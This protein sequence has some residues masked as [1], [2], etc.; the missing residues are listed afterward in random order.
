MAYIVVGF[1]CFCF[2][3]FIASVLMAGDDDRDE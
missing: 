1:I 3:F 2:G